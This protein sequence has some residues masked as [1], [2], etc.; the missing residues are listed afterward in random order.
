MIAPFAFK[1]L[2][3]YTREQVDLLNWYNRA[4][5]GQDDWRAWTVEIFSSLLEK[6]AGR[7]VK[8]IQTHCL[9]ADQPP[10]DYLLTGSQ[11]L[12]GRGEECEVVLPARAVGKQHARIVERETNYY[13][14]DLGS[15]LGTFIEQRKLAPHQAQLMRSGDTFTIFPYRFELKVER[16]WSPETRVEISSPRVEPLSWAAFGITSRPGY[17]RCAV[18]VHPGGGMAC[19]EVGRTFLE[20]VL[21]RAI[22]SML[23]AS[24][25]I[26]AA[27]DGVFEF[28]LLALIERANRK[29]AFPLQFLPQFG[30]AFEAPP[31]ANGLEVSFT[32]G[33]TDLAGAIRLWIPYRLLQK[34][35]D[36]VPP[37][38]DFAVPAGVTWTFL[39][40]A[41]HVDLS[42]EEI[43]RLE[44]SDILLFTFEAEIHFPGGARRGWQSTL[45]AEE[46]WQVQAGTY[47]ERNTPMPDSAADLSHI[48]L[49]L[50]VVLGE[51]ELTLAE[52]GGLAGGTVIALDAGKNDP[53]RLAING[54]VVG[55]GQLVEIDGKMGVKIL[56]WSGG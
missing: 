6:P 56:S 19:L 21:G 46:P 25:P 40:S 49:R 41:G 48:P 50:H 47:F 14:E 43:S 4:I 44:P 23:L 22:D 34:V 12:I 24:I 16:K 18:E 45:L 39:V 2:E 35:R 55:E 36:L 5:P 15:T 9:E 52:A 20:G 32:A 31:D 51:K 29:L 17:R 3:T 1:T 30:A 13:L 38:P 26:L 27:D 53:V 37:P 8:I 42:L 10:Q 7:D 54:R 11:L 33:L 28:L